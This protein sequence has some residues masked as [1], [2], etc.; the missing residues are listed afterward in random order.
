MK[1]TLCST[2]QLKELC[3][4]KDIIAIMLLRILPLKK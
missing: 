3:E 1:G 2:Q 4:R